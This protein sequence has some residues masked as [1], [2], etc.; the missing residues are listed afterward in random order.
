MGTNAGWVAE[1]LAGKNLKIK[2]VMVIWLAGC[3]FD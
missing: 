1:E 2:R 3:A